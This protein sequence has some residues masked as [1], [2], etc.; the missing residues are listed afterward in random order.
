MDDVAAKT[1][2]APFKAPLDLQHEI[3]QFLFF[4][5]SLIDEHRFRDWLG[6]LAEDVTYTL[7]TNTQALVRDRRRGVAPPRSYIFHDNKDTLERRV[8][9]LE[10]GFAWAEEP[11]SRTRHI[12]TNIRILAVAGDEVTVTLNYLVHRAAKQRD[13]HSFIGTRV[14]RVRRHGESWLVASRA[15]ELDE[16]VLMSASVPIFI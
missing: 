10:S 3:E 4:E 15:L 11:Q 2:P 7:S 6:L 5:A 12:L 9:R 8:A 1:A 14:D 13:H 16:F